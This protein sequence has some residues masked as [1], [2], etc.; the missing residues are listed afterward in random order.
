MLG[1]RVCN[2]D[3]NYCITVKESINVN[4]VLLIHSLMTE[5]WSVKTNHIHF[6]VL[7][8]LFDKSYSG[9][10]LPS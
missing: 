6:C 7:F 5:Y 8:Y 3:P 9:V 4:N 1:F 2:A 10:F